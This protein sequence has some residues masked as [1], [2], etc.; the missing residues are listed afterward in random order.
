MQGYGHSGGFND[1]GAVFIGKPDLQRQEGEA[2]DKHGQRV[3]RQ[4]MGERNIKNLCPNPELGKPGSQLL[5][6]DGQERSGRRNRSRRSGF[7]PR[8]QGCPE[9]LRAR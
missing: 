1:I 6:G 9:H 8:W 4:A 2:E 5:N 3:F 7:T